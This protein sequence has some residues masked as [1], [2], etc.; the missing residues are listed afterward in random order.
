[1]FGRF[2]LVTLAAL[3]LTGCVFDL[4]SED[5]KPKV[6]AVDA[7]PPRDEANWARMEAFLAANK[8]KEGVTVTDSGLQYRVVRKG[9][10]TRQPTWAS[11]VMVNY[12]GTLIDGTVFDENKGVEFEA[13]QVIKGWQEALELMREGDVFELVIPS[14][15]AYG[16]RGKGRN[17]TGDQVLLF[18]VE[19][20]KI[21]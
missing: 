16:C 12:R 6:R 8:V 1:M 3:T 19:L 21:K 9:T 14:G 5:P 18:S 15:L 2:A 10:G 17:I 7:C 4:S 20:L 11:M 13:G